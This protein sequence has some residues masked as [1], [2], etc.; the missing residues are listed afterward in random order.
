MIMVRICVSVGAPVPIS[1]VGVE[2]NLP[3]ITSEWG[4]NDALSSTADMQFQLHPNNS[5]MQPSSLVM[6]GHSCVLI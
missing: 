2:V 4:R 5:H 6:V 1:L 3:D